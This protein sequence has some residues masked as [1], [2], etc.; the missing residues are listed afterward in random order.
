MVA[1][2]AGGN[3]SFCFLGNHGSDDG[4]HICIWWLRSVEVNHEDIERGEVLLDMVENSP[5]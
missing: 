4:C 2:L 1:V 3:H 5:V